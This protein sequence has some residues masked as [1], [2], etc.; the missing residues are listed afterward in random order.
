MHFGCLGR[1]IAARD[2]DERVACA[3]RVD[4]KVQC[5]N[6]ALQC[7]TRGDR[8]TLGRFLQPMTARVTRPISNQLH[9]DAKTAICEETGSFLRRNTMS[10]RLQAKDVEASARRRTGMGLQHCSNSC[11]HHGRR[12]FTQT[13]YQKGLQK[14]THTSRGAENKRESLPFPKNSNR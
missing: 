3:G 1:Y 14:S 6:G 11:H 12:I 8:L 2:G 10:G 7:E 9:D 13:Q 4:L 5:S